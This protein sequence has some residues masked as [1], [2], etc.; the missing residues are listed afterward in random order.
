VILLNDVELNLT[1]GLPYSRRIRVTDGA[2]IWPTLDL[3]EVRSEVR[4]S[5]IWT[6][7]LKATLSPFIT[8]SIEGD[9][10][11]LDLKLTGAQTRE[12]SGGHYDVVVT[13]KGSVDDRGIRV[14]KGVLR[15]EQLTTGA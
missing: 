12:L 13:D 6:S 5:P 4:V 2:K 3:L 7:R 9:D 8:P 1:G 15:I 14:L 10:L 11:I